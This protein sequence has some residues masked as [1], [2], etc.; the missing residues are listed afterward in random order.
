MP[1]TTLKRQRKWL[2]HGDT[3][4]VA[5]ANGDRLGEVMD[6]LRDSGQPAVFV[7]R[8]G[9]DWHEE[10]DESTLRSENLSSD[11]F[12][13]AAKRLAVRHRDAKAPEGSHSQSHRRLI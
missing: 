4:L 8:P 12:R 1:D 6:V 13:E 10:T 7:L 2:L 3:V 11:Q 9:Q 5:Q